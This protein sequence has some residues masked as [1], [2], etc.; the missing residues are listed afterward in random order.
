VDQ[1]K[2]T[3]LPVC[4]QPIP[5]ALKTLGQWVCWAYTYQPRRNPTKPWTKVPKQPDSGRNARSTNPRTWGSFDQAMA[6]YHGQGLDGIGF[7][8]TED[9][10]YVAIDLDGCRNPETGEIQPWAQA[11]IDR[12]TSYTE[13]SPSGTGIR[14]FVKGKLPPHGRKKGAIEVCDRARFVTVTGCQLTETS[15]LIEDRQAELEA[16]HAEVFGARGAHASGHAPRAWNGHGPSAHVSDEAILE[17]ARRSANGEKFAKLWA[18]DV[19]G[20]PS[21]SEADLALCGILAFWTR[22]RA[23][24][25][26]LFRQS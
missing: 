17:K 22:D 20:Y 10:D 12:F 25:D 15:S 5:E 9:D 16:F 4:P 13:V 26:R 18:G 7:V 24:I 6:R 14:V 23:Q 11:I 2:P 21:Q 19:S 8:V 3:P 1:V